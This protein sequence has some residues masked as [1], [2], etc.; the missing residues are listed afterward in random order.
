MDT[1][2]HFGFAGLPPAPTASGLKP[3]APSSGDNPYSNGAALSF[4]PQGKSEYGGQAGGVCS[5]GGQAGGEGG[6]QQRGPGSVCEAL[7]CPY[8]A[9]RAVGGFLGGVCCV[10]PSL[11]WP[12]WGLC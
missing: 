3:T 11:K 10:P 6:V 5:R 12:G 9:W 2:N 4:P 8:G 7:G 1:D